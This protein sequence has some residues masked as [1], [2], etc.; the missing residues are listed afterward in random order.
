MVRD[1]D[2]ARPCASGELRRRTRIAREDELGRFSGGTACSVPC[3]RLAG[4]VRIL[5][6]SR[7]GL[8]GVSVVC[9]LGIARGED[10]KRI[11]IIGETAAAQVENYL[12]RLTGD[13]EEEKTKTKTKR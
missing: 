3:R 9:R 4:R 8:A 6:I 7:G 10:E 1:V 12:R 13:E 5:C 11:T 2:D